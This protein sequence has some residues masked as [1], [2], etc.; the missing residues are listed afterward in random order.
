MASRNPFWNQVPSLRSLTGPTKRWWIL[1]SFA[2]AAEKAYLYPGGFVAEA[3]NEP[4]SSPSSSDFVNSCLIIA[5][6]A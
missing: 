4:S 3:V 5:T 1:F 6:Q 2:S